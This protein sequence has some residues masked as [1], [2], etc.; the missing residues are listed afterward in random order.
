[1][2]FGFVARSGFLTQVLHCEFHVVM[3]LCSTV[4]FPESVLDCEE[5]LVACLAG[6]V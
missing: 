5:T 4:C 3:A 6:Y 1:M 2:K